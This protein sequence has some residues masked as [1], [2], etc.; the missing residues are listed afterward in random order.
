MNTVIAAFTFCAASALVGFP[1]NDFGQQES[2]GN[3]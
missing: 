2:G 1:A 3:K